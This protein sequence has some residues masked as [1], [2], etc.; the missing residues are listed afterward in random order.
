[1]EGW[2]QS[3]T[4]PAYTKVNMLIFGIFLG[5][6]EMQK[7]HRRG[8][9]SPMQYNGTKALFLFMKMILGK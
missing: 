4:F 2:P 9:K 8:T 3:F 1:M 7:G 6:N 5:C